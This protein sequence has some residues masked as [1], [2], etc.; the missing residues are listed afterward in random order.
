MAKRRISLDDFEQ[1]QAAK[2]RPKVKLNLPDENQVWLAPPQAAAYLGLGLSTLA[3]MRS[4]GLGPAWSQPCQN[5]IRYSR[6][7]LD[8]FMASK[9]VQ[10]AAE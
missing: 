2:K 6:A 7:A 4:T 9:A 10:Q 1:K 3:K 5:S 8:A